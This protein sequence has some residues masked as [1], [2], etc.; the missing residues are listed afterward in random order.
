ML[1]GVIIKMCW[2]AEV[3]LNTFIFGCISA[4]LVYR[5][6]IIENKY[7]LIVLSFTSIQILE[8]FI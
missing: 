2:N 6:G 4:I 5:L 8:Y 3:S 1:K 7:I